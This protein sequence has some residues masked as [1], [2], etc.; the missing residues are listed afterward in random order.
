MLDLVGAL[1]N[2]VVWLVCHASNNNDGHK[3]IRRG[4]GNGGVQV[5]PCSPYSNVGARGHVVGTKNQG[6]ESVWQ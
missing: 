3:A 6:F 2:F 1:Q 4:N 5:V